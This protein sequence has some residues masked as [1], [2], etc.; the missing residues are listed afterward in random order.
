MNLVK[1]GEESLSRSEQR[2]E[3]KALDSEI[4]PQIWSNYLMLQ[5]SSLLSSFALCG[6]IGR[7]RAETAFELYLRKCI[8]SHRI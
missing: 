8:M 4:G 3:K 5:V 1:K 2:E 6:F 7:G